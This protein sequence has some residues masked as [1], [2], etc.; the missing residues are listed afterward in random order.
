LFWLKSFEIAT[1]FFPYGSGFG[2]YGNAQALKY[3]S[4]L[5]REY[6]MSSVY[7]LME[8]C[9]K[10][11]VAFG[12]DTFWPA[13]IAQ[14]NYTGT[15]AYFILLV[16][17]YF[18]ISKLE[19]YAFYFVGLISFLVIA[20]QTISNSSFFSPYVILPGFMVGMALKSKYK[21]RS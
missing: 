1:D 12:S 18:K 11:N 7:G 16:L 5:Y 19:N 17:L 10:C 20:H 13:L 8:D 3:Y 15:L 9:D 2:T 21:Y 14:T 6:G 4:P